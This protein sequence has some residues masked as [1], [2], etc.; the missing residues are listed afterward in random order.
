MNCSLSHTTSKTIHD[1]SLT[2]NMEDMSCR[3]YWGFDF[4]G[5][6]SP[7]NL[8]TFNYEVQEIHTGAGGVF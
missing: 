6:Y 2:T 7:V 4:Q 1:V 5:F 3:I 8:G